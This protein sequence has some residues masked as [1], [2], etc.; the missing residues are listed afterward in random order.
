MKESFMLDYF[1]NSGLL[2]ADESETKTQ[3]SEDVIKDKQELEKLLDKEQMKIFIRLLSNLTTH[4]F[5]LRDEECSKMFH[6]G[7][8][9][10]IEI[11]EFE[12]VEDN[13]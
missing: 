5:I 6:L 2:C 8:R 4:M 7:I 9:L 3:F 13:C 12:S 10:G 1:M 11:K